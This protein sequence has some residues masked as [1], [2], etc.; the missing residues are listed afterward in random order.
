MHDPLPEHPLRLASSTLT[1]HVDHAHGVARR[2][3]GCDHL[4]HDAVQ[5]A[6]V[7]L[8]REAIPPVDL[9]GWL[10]RA[11]VFRARHLRRTLLRRQKHE[12]GAASHCELHAGC[13]N[14]LHHAY[15]HEL[16]TRLDGAL[17]ALPPEQRTAFELYVDTGLDY[18][19]IAQRLSLPI[20]TVRS[21]LYRARQA[22]LE[23]LGDQAQD[24]LDASP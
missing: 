16:G 9:R 4:A 11:V 23:A 21:R 17:D 13:D 10:V 1:P 3:L 8:W 19:G 5:E 7:A 2:L 14:P 22:L 12:H 6:L 15:A 18:R 24:H 20:G